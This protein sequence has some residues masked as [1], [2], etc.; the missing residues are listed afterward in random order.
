MVAERWYPPLL[1]CCA[2]KLLSLPCQRCPEVYPKVLPDLSQAAPAPSAAARQALFRL[3][4]H[5]R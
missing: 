1:R 4:E 5:P 3:Q 2:P